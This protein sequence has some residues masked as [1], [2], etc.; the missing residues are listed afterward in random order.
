[1]GTALYAADF[2]QLL[3]QR[4]GRENARKAFMSRLQSLNHSEDAISCFQQELRRALPVAEACDDTSIA[5]I[6]VTSRLVP[7]FKDPATSLKTFTDRASAALNLGDKSKASAALLATAAVYRA[8][9]STEEELGA[10]NEALRLA[11]EVGDQRGEV[12]ALHFLVESQLLSA[13]SEAAA[14]ATEAL[15]ISKLLGR[16]DEV[17][18]A[19]LV[20]MVHARTG[21]ARGATLALQFAEQA[22]ATAAALGD[23]RAQAAAL[24]ALVAAQLAAK[25][26]S[27][28]FKTADQMLQIFKELGEKTWQARTLTMKANAKVIEGDSKLALALGTEALILA[29]E[30]APESDVEELALR[31]LISA[32]CGLDYK[33][34]LAAAK[35]LLKLGRRQSLRGEAVAM[36][37]VARV[38]ATMFDWVQAARAAQEAQQ[39]ALEAK[40]VQIQVA[41]LVVKTEAEGQRP[42]AAQQAAEEVL[43]LLRAQSDKRRE[44][45]A[46]LL[47]AD[48]HPGS[49]GAVAASQEA[50]AAYRALGSKVGEASALLAF[51]RAMAQQ[52]EPQG[53]EC[54]DAAQKSAAT[55][56]SLS[57]S[58]GEGAALCFLSIVHSA[59]QNGVDADKSAK[60]AARVFESFGCSE[61]AALAQHLANSAKTASLR[62]SAARIFVDHDLL[63][64]IEMNEIATQESLEAAIQTSHNLVRAK[65]ESSPRVALVHLEGCPSP[66]NLHSYA[67]TSGAFSVGLRG[68]GM[69]C[70]VVCWGK[71]AGPSWN[72]FLL[73]DYR[74]AAADT[75]FLLPLCNPPECIVHLLG[76][77]VSTQLT[78]MSGSISAQ[79][80][81]EMGVIHQI[82]DSKDEA[83]R[84]GLEMAKRIAKWPPVG[85]KQTLS[86][87]A[88]L[89]TQ[90]VVPS[91][92][93]GQ[94]P[95]APKVVKA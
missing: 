60:E 28:A 82:H 32:N 27:Q 55:F 73:G 22:K 10:A 23:K 42:R 17:A 70:L 46:L 2:Y 48:A 31:T 79:H 71:I 19:C 6:S 40:D 14:T 66:S 38:H 93:R 86:L 53:Q 81:L 59:M 7:A 56:K 52:A 91:G 63:F 67:I 24:G 95:P 92:L 18:A 49:P 65:Y 44:A 58:Y 3:G 77:A 68:T 5:V 62:P 41:A 34:A 50:L 57:E 11:R 15:A 30:V 61:G 21:R 20:A 80:L 88:P 35:D 54:L 33:P 75:E 84:Y 25:A 26:Y 43:C 37:E 39:L 4:R 8:A 87:M 94:L 1:M 16:L 90:Y 36:V 47:L 85:I 72:L 74:V 13:G 83:E 45:S 9:G 69:P 51:G 78:M 29:R 12:Q 76:H 89:A 64:H